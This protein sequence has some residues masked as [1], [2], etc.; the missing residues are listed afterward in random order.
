MESLV[1][2]VASG[3]KLV[4]TIA[5]L[6]G[7]YPPLKA[8]A[9]LP[10]I[11]GR[12]WKVYFACLGIGVLMSV[13]NIR[14]WLGHFVRDVL[15]TGDSSP[16]AAL[17]ALFGGRHRGM[18][19]EAGEFLVTWSGFHLAAL[20]YIIITIWIWKAGRRGLSSGTPDVAQKSE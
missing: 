8:K 1:L 18:S 3:L 15:F 10:K 6:V 5:L 2:L 16:F 17:N 14:I 13:L 19:Y 7:W 12:L 4:L 11:A 9:R 20:A